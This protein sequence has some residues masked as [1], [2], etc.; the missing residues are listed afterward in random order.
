MNSNANASQIEASTTALVP[1]GSGTENQ[2]RV[3][4]NQQQLMKLS[5]NDLDAEEVGK[6]VN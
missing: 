6:V 2:R 1:Y 5:L 4:E 3:K